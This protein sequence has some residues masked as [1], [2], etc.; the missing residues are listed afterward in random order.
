MKKEKT[1]DQLFRDPLNSVVRKKFAH[2]N[3][4]DLKSG[5][6]A[7]QDKQYFYPTVALAPSNK[8]RLN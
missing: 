1:P 5:F 2:T 3:F 7:A 6:E 8:L 4:L